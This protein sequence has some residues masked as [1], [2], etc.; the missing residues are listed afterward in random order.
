MQPCFNRDVISHLSDQATT[1]LLELG[2]WAEG[3]GLHFSSSQT[4]QT[5]SPSAADD[6][7]Y[8]LDPQVSQAIAAGNLTAIEEWASRLASLP[9]GSERI[10][11]AEH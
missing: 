8:D 5:P 7:D 2:A 11:N 6:D 9:D 10:T 1:N 4:R 3:E